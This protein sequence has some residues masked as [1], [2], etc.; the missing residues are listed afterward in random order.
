MRVLL[1]TQSW[2]WLQDERMARFS[3]R[4]LKLLNQPSTERLLSLASIWELSIKF[5][6]GKLRLPDAPERYVVARLETSM[7]RPLDIEL[8]HVLHVAQLPMHHRDPFD[9]L[10]VAQAV[11]DRLSVL[12]AD[13]RLALYG[14]DLLP[15]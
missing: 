7:T 9:R 6:I 3:R 15:L 13:R 1:D 14:I 11:L 10:L 12:S 2:L 5:S 4:T 8:R